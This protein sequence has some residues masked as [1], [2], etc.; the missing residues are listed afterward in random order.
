MAS[1]IKA[2]QVYAQH[3]QSLEAFERPV[4][5]SGDHIAL[6]KEILEEGEASEPPGPQGADVV[7]A[8]IAAGGRIKWVIMLWFI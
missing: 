8:Q 7:V 1:K 4:V 5:E 2:T 6:Q 3:L